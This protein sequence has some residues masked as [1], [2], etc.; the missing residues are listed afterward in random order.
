MT[1][2]DRLITSDNI[3]A[4]ASLDLPSRHADSG[5]PPRQSLRLHA[6]HGHNASAYLSQAALALLLPNDA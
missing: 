3:V 6:C 1:M 2:V 5:D 4:L